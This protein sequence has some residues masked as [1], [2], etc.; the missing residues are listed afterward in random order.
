MNFEI[1]VLI[2]YNNLGKGFN[3]LS[4]DSVKILEY[5]INSMNNNRY[6]NQEI[7]VCSVFSGGELVP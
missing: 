6:K 5:C 7:L 2:L 3:N 4:G 1:A